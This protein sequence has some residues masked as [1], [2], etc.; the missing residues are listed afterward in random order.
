MHSP[1]RQ[2][3]F[4]IVELMIV[5]ALLGIIA[6]IAVP[7][8]TQFIRNNQVQAKAEEVHAL[9]QYARAQAVATRKGYAVNFQNWQVTSGGNVE[10]QLEINSNLIVTATPQAG[11][12]YDGRGMASAV[13]TITVAHTASPEDCFQIDVRASGSVRKARAT[14][15]P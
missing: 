5:L 3:G 10:R 13:A 14:C 1:S 9:L 6:A 7:N 8:F 4:T 11:I 2:R 15:S 12:Q